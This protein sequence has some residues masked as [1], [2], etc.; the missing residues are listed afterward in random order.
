MNDQLGWG[1][2]TTKYV[3]LNDLNLSDT[4]ARKEQTINFEIISVINDKDDLN[5]VMTLVTIMT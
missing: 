4:I 1:S 3:I 5:V 2:R